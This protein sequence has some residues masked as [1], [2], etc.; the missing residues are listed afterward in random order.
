MEENLED[1]LNEFNNVVGRLVMHHH[2]EAS[3]KNKDTYIREA[4]E[5]HSEMSQIRA[6]SDTPTFNSV[7]LL[8]NTSHEVIERLID[9]KIFS[10]C[11]YT[12]KD[13]SISSNIHAIT[14]ESFIKAHKKYESFENIKKQAVDYFKQSQS[15]KKINRTLQ[16]SP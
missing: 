10:Y 7:R 3:K 2:R 14:K 13:G 4:L 6:L 1:I 15:M 8:L 16:M 11:A 5:K 12:K 9:K